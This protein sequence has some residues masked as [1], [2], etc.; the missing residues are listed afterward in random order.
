MNGKLPDEK[1]DF[2]HDFRFA[3]N[4]ASLYFYGEQE[5]SDIAGIYWVDL[6]GGAP[7]PY[8]KLYAPALGNIQQADWSADSTAIAYRVAESPS[9]PSNSPV[10]LYV[11]SVLEQAPKPRRINRQLYCST[12][13]ASTYCPGVSAFAFQP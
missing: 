5:V 11:S 1:T 12:T 8:T 4:S 10:N 3:P 7:A 9:F 6:S 13:G 2:I